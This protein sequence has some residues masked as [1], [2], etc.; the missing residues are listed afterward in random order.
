[1]INA[2]S[3]GNTI[4]VTGPTGGVAAGGGV[5]VGA[6]L[7]VAKSA[8]AESAVGVGCLTG[9]YTLP[10]AT[11]AV[12]QGAIAYWNNTNK[13]VTT[14]ASGNTAIGHFYEA[15]VSGATSVAVRLAP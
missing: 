11:G 6:V 15:A 3:D 10:K 8:I 13:N 12:T 14:T 2:I 9:V 7:A 1:M 5:L 4:P